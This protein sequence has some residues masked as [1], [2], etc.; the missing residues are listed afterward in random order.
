MPK[1]TWVDASAKPEAHFVDPGD[2]MGANTELA[3]KEPGPP[4]S[5]LRD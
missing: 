5:T 3:V 2:W 4:L 1:E